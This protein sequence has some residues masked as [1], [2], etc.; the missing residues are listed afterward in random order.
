MQPNLGRLPAECV[1]RDKDGNITGYRS[2]HVV[3]FGG[4]STSKADAAPW[5]SRDLRVPTV[6]TISDPPH[7]Y[8]IEHWSLT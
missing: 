2:V 1:V 5:P 6:W 4:Y 8:E 7:A 3:L